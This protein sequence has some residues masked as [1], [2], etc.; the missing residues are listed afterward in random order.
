MHCAADSVLPIRALSKGTAMALIRILL[1][2]VSVFVGVAATAEATPLT[3]YFSSSVDLSGSGGAAVN[4][5]SGFF[6][7]ETTAT[8]A[9][10]EPPNLAIY[11]LEAYQLILNGVDRTLGPGDAGLFVFNDVEAFETG[12]NVDALMLF[13]TIEKNAVTGDTALIGALSGPSDTWNTIS[14]PTDYSFLSLLPTRFSGLSL[15]V[16]GEGDENDILLGT[17][18]FAVTPIPEPAILTLTALGLAGVIARARRG[19]QRR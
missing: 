1:L 3:L 5:F 9:D 18:S 16:P 2:G 4:P 17:G 10:S 8:P 7:W 12:T 11:P 6:T 15:E 19:R 14:L 13:V